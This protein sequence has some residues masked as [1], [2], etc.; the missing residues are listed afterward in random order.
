M[1]AFSKPGMLRTKRSCTSNGRLVE[2]PLGYTSWVVSPSGSTKIWCE[3]R[4][5]KRWILSST[6]G[7]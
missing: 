3:L 2:M 4:S 7:Q 1:C 5:A 6:D